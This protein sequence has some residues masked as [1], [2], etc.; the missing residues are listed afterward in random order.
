MDPSD[1]ALYA[2]IGAISLAFLLW[3]ATNWHVL[4]V[5]RSIKADIDA[6]RLATETFVSGQIA[7]IERSVAD[8][9][10]KVSSIEMPP[11]PPGLD[12]MEERFNGLHGELNDFAAAV[13]EDM[14]AARAEIEDLP[15]RLRMEQLALRGQ[16]QNAFQGAVTAAG[17]DVQNA[18]SV[19]E[20]FATQDP[21]MMKLALMKRVAESKVSDA[22]AEKNPVGA[23]LLEAGRF[24]ML[25]I[26][27]AGNPFESRG[28]RRAPGVPSAK[29]SGSSDL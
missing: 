2:A 17:E 7:R 14:T 12:S 21:E 5:G 9:S 20:A 15:R 11:L 8:V 29:R 23:M 19:R 6:K 22:Y 28:S 26:L 4:R 18:L 25:E 3:A 10:A 27:Q 1:M 24:K 16:E 13:R